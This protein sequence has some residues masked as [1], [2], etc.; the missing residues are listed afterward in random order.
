M[1][2]PAH[3]FMQRSKV[4]PRDIGFGSIHMQ[5]SC[6]KAGMYYMPFAWSLRALSTK[7]Y[8]GARVNRQNLDGHFVCLTGQ[9]D[10]LMNVRPGARNFQLA[11]SSPGR[12]ERL[13]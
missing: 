3:S 2:D 1:E 12:P 13:H 5:A 7:P 6:D 10:W 9:P 11:L 4:S 8:S